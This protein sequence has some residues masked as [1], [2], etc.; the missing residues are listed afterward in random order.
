MAV[1]QLSI[2]KLIDAL[3][4]AGFTTKTDLQTF[5]TKDDLKNFATKDDLGIFATKEDLKDFATKND[6]KNFA[7]KE[8]LKSF[9]TKD[10]LR[11]L[12]TTEIV[13]KIVTETVNQTVMEASD[14]ILSGVEI[15]NTAMEKRLNKKM[16]TN[17]NELKAEIGYLKDRSKGLDAELSKTATKVE[18]EKLK[19]RVTKLEAQI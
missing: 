18:H 1:N 12:P 8:D 6:L 2:P 16:D 15:M 5:A 13:Q 4:K 3:K 11:A 17:Q 14:A 7:T 19:I 9:A 10:D